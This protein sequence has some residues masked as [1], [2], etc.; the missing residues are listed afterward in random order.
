MT[1]PF[2]NFGRGSA[3]VASSKAKINQANS[4]LDQVRRDIKYTKAS[5]Y[6]SLVGSLNARNK[7][8]DSYNNVKLQRETFS[9][10]MGSTAF[11]ITAY[12]EAAI[13]EISIY[14]QLIKNEKQL[15]MSSLQTSHSSERLL[16][17]FRIYIN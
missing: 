4:K 1:F 2:F 9:Y 17:R 13:R 8:L 11:S 7:I 10:Q 6:G 16:N 5:N 12:L 3:Q 15:L 14:E